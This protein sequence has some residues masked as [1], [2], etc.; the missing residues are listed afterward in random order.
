[1]IKEFT[2]YRTQPLLLTR[3]ILDKNPSCMHPSMLCLSTV[4]LLPP[5]TPIATTN[6]NPSYAFPPVC[7]F[8]NAIRSFL[9]AGFLSPAKTIFVPLMYFLG[10]SK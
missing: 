7:S 1:M 3:V 2:N 10:A 6:P 9:S 4:S 8:K 5:F